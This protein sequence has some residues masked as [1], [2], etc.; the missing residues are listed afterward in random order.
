M[1][2]KADWQWF[3]S[4]IVTLAT[5]FIGLWLNEKGLFNRRTRK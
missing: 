3:V 5:P 1:I 2:D 4:I